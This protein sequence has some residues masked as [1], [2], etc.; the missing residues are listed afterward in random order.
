MTAVRALDA[1]DPFREIRT[2]FPI[3][4]SRAYLF[5]GGMAPLSTPAREALSAYAD[6]WTDDPVVAY[7][8][9]PREEADALRAAVA[10]HLNAR[11]QDIAILDSTSRGNNLAVQMIDALRGANVVVDS[12]TYPSA[13]FPWLLPAKAHVE[14]RRVPDDEDGL[15]R[16]EEFER[17]V[18]EETV[19]IS[20]SHVSPAS[21]FRHQLRALADLAHRVG[22]FL[23]VDAAQSVGAVQI[24]AEADRVDMMAFGAM[25]WLLGTPG[26]GFL[27][28]N[29]TTADR[30]TLPQAGPAGAREVGER[31]VP[32]D[33]ALRHEL[34]SLHW[35]GLAASRRGAELLLELGLGEVEKHVLSLSGRVIGGMR[36]RGFN[37]LTPVVPTQRAGIVAFRHRHA[38]AVRTH[39]RERGVD[40]WAWPDR[41]LVRADPHVYNNAGDVDR[42]LH[43]LDTFDSPE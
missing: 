29:P 5:A 10:R 39:L 9:H 3:T 14:I 41:Q 34:S 40:V 24:D 17:L 19:A 18:D 15:P 6:S 25:K 32:A 31:L 36:E 28:V 22:A 23:L 20:V 27:Y 26:I 37:V 7:R 12:T 16:L 2:L 4:Q 35:G 33:G 30:L 42:L 11:P 13:L 21:G 8:R 38:E 43:G 1:D